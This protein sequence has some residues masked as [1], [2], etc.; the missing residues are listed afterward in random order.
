MTHTSLTERLILRK[1]TVEDADFLLELFNTPT[2][3]KYIGDRNIHT[4]EEAAEYITNGP[5]PFYATHGFGSYCLQLR[6]SGTRIGMCG[7]YKRDNLNYYDLGFALLP[8][9]EGKGYARE[10]CEYVL[11]ESRDVLHMNSLLAITNKS[12]DRS[13]Q[14]LQRLGFQWKGYFSFEGS[15]QLL[16]CLQLPLTE[17]TIAPP[18]TISLTKELQPTEKERIRTI[19]NS[20]YP[21]SL[22]LQTP[23]DF[24]RYL[25]PLGQ[26]QHYLMNDLSGKLRGWGITFEREN[27]LWFAMILDESIQGTGMGTMLLKR[28]QAGKHQL[29]GWVI[30]HHNAFR[31]DGKPYLSP[32]EF[33]LKNKFTIEPETRLELPSIS[34]VCIRYNHEN[35]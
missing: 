15:D 22:L 30:D 20:V 12:N 11:K 8:E 16:N 32:V 26:K 34:A 24:E 35:N 9:F 10:A 25:E 3:L 19:W 2:W 1:V 23:D 21:E 4:V 14:L 17:K 31:A 18:L 28:M 13:I 5:L 29:S 7:L 6:D 33:Y 27:A